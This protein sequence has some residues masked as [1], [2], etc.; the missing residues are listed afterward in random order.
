LGHPGGDSVLR[1]L[2]K[3]KKYCPLDAL[4]AQMIRHHDV[5][6]MINLSGE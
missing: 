1:S 5:E 6:Y 3:D 2:R 4:A